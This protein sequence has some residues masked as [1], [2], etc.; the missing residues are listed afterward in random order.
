MFKDKGETLIDQYLPTFKT[1]RQITPD[2]YSIEKD[3]YYYSINPALQEEKG[4]SH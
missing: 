1:A 3:S 4:S 2:F